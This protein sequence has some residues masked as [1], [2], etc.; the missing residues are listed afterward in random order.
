MIEIYLFVNPLDKASL[1]MEQ[2]L[3]KIISG[4]T[5]KIHFRVIP[6]L[7]PRVIHNYVLDQGQ[8]IHDLAYR[9]QLFNSIYSACLD[10]KAVQLQGKKLGTKFLFEI[11]KQVGFFNQNYSENLVHSILESLGADIPL[12]TVDRQS[13]LI[14]DF[15]KLDQQVAQEMGI[16][17][18]SDAVI[19]N[20]NCERDFGVLVSFDTPD[21][22]IVELFK[23][24]CSRDSFSGDDTRLHLY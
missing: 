21:R 6:F 20:Y 2:R 13:P 17:N 1:I 10:Y 4:E 5:E 7:N 16:E 15:F 12:F 14:E 9:N 11:Q 24:S 3:L 18:F 22:D 23:T 8:S 19:F